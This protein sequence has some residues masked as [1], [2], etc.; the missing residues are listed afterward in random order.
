MLTWRPLCETIARVSGWNLR[1]WSLGLGVALLSIAACGARSDLP[2]GQGRGGADPEPDVR[3]AG[4]DVKDAEPP[5]DAGPDVADVA[6]AEIKDCTEEGITYIYV[7]TSQNELLRF[8]PPDATFTA[9]G[10]I[11]CPTT[12][13][14]F[15]MAVD[16]KGRAYIVFQN[17]ELFRV[18][19]ATAACKSTGFTSAETG[20]SLFGMAFATDEKGSEETLFIADSSFDDLPSAGFGALN[21]DT[22]DF[23]FIGP[24]S[25]PLGN[26]VEFTGTGDGRLFGYFIDSPQGVSHIAEVDKETGA[27]QS[28]VLLTFSEPTSSFA[29][30]FW[31]GDFYVFHA[32]GGPTVVTRY[33][34]DDGSLVDVASLPT[35]VVGV[36]VSTCAPQ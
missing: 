19:T 32:G 35:H 11:S 20:F 22:F 7:V 21:V 14:P 34:P 24:F 15:S 3:D 2:V 9:I 27:L 5:E 29:F 8:N 36:G 12:A 26:A 10:L 17:G 16:R 18:S 6:D 1:A 33:R 28:D 25:A 4:P 23:K 31:G 30:A 13:T